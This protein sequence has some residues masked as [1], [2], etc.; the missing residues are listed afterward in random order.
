MLCRI[1][2][3]SLLITGV[4]TDTNS[5][6]NSENGSHREL[7]VKNESA[8]LKSCLYQC[9]FE[10]YFNGSSA[11]PS[12]CDTYDN[13]TDLEFDSGL[14][15]MGAFYIQKKQTNRVVFWTYVCSNSDNCSTDYYNQ[16]ISYYVGLT[17]KVQRLHA[18][19]HKILDFTGSSS[20]NVQQCYNN[21]DKLQS[22]INGSCVY[23]RIPDSNAINKRC[24][25]PE[26]FTRMN[27]DIFQTTTP[28]QSTVA[29][30][31]IAF[32]CNRD[33]CNSPETVTA[34]ERVIEKDWGGII[35]N[36]T[37]SIN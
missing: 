8:K 16:Y 13:G 37:A 18:R 20:S 30:P 26:D 3:T 27:Y 7:L 25:L 24:S 1:I 21:S 29:F 14:G 23:E 2:I 10:Y 19:L 33:K 28:A 36:N 22:C 12:T 31:L 35:N 4:L 11:I 17:K 5:L 15:S 6:V 32:V 9:D 34:I